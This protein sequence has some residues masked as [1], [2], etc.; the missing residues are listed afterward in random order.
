MSEQNEELIDV[1][2]DAP[3]EDAPDNFYI[4][5]LSGEAQTPSPNPT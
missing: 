1:M 4:D 3:E 2:V 5:I